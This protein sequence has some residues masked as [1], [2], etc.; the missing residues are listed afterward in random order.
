MIR[1]FI[2]GAL[3][4]IVTVVV[5]KQIMIPLYRTWRNNQED[6][7]EG[8]EDVEQEITARKKKQATKPKAKA[9]K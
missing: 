8:T 7:V 6:I 4:V 9:K 5:A 1:V 3:I 2:F